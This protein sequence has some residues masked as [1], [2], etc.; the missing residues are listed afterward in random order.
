[1][2]DAGKLSLDYDITKLLPALDTRGTKVTWRQMPDHTPGMQT[3]AAGGV[4]DPRLTRDSAYLLLK[5]AP[6][7]FKFL[8]GEA[9]AYDGGAYWLLG[10]VVEKARGGGD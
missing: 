1:M 2:R 6:V 7:K 8:P 4:F 5:R 10:L 3:G 9:Q